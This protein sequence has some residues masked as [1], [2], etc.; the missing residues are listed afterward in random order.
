MENRNKKH[1]SEKEKEKEDLL[2]SLNV[3]FADNPSSFGYKYYIELIL[4]DLG[5]RD[6]EFFYLVLE[7]FSKKR[8]R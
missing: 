3:L 5:I 6:Y 7:S 2:N 1:I 4:K 8:K